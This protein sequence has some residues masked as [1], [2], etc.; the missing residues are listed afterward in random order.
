[1][2]EPIVILEPGKVIIVLSEVAKLPLTTELLHPIMT[3][4]SS[5][6]R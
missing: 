3:L 1:M 4:T 2:S 6:G 5:W